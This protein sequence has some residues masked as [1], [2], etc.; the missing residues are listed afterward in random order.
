M[1]SEWAV[2]F[3]CKVTGDMSWCRHNVTAI[4]ACRAYNE[5]L[6]HRNIREK[7]EPPDLIPYDTREGDMKYLRYWLSVEPITTIVNDTQYH[8]TSQHQ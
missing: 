1:D 5:D 6:I 8:D 2:G 4:A 3:I 7:H